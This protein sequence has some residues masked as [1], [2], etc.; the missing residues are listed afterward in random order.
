MFLER[1][2]QRW[3][4][5]VIRGLLVIAFGILTVAEPPTAVMVLVFIFGVYAIADGLTTL[6]A[7]LS[8]LA[9]EKGG[10]L[11][12]LGGLVSIAAGIIALVWP[13]ITAMA[14][15]FV[16]AWWAIILGIT[17]I[18]SAIAY[19]KVMENEWAVILSGML[20]IAFGVIL[21][22]WPGPGVVAVLALI[23]TFAIIRGVMFIVA[24]AR[25]RKLH[26]KLT[27]AAQ[28]PTDVT[29]R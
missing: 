20:W 9:P 16:I 14:L 29:R 19:S 25:L 18:I 11:Y 28:L 24:G 4:T 3:W 7:V 21:L 8:P 13:G 10:W 17:E 26:G 23:A 15:F 2:T 1:A 12:A 5:L 22:V 6:S 27:S